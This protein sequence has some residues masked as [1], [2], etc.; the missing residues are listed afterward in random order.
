MHSLVNLWGNRLWLRLDGFRWYPTF[1]K[2]LTLDHD[3]LQLVVAKSL[4][5]CS[6]LPDSPLSP[7]P[8]PAR[9]SFCLL[10]NPELLVSCSFHPVPK[11]TTTI[12]LIWLGSL[13]SRSPQGITMSAIL[14]PCTGTSRPFPLGLLRIPPTTALSAQRNYFTVYDWPQCNVRAGGLCAPLLGTA[15]SFPCWPSSP[16]TWQF[17][18]DWAL[19][20]WLRK[21]WLPPWPLG[22]P[23][24]CA[25]WLLLVFLLL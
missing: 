8:Y 10:P 21:A 3:T 24:V 17:A 16:R 4:P 18:A 9:G 13:S 7:T 25:G 1:S 14:S 11:L 23:E 12:M 6:W 19:V 22:L 2:C 5:I 20:F 15:A